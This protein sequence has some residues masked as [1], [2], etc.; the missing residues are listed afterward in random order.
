MT[1]DTLREQALELWQQGI[2]RQMARD[3]YAAENLYRQSLALH[4]TAEAHT[5]LGWVYSSRGNVEAALEECHRAVELDPDFGNPY[6]DIGAY[7]IEQRKLDEAIPWLERAKGA[8]RY[9]ARHFPCLNLA[10]I[11]AKKGLVVRALG[12]LEEAE[13]HHAG[14]TTVAQMRQELRRLN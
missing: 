13:S 10:R 1:P 8:K 12:E 5:F 6:N 7:L 11:Y 4:P 14:D 2:E 9:D 3:L